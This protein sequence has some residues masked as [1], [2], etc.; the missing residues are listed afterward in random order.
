VARQTI[1]EIAELTDAVEKC[2]RLTY[3]E[4]IF[5]WRGEWGEAD[6]LLD[7]LI[8]QVDRYSIASYRGIAMALKGELLVKTG[9]PEE[10]CRRL[11]AADSMLK[12]TRNTALDTTFAAALAEGLAATG[13]SDEALVTLEAAI[14]LAY[15]RGGTWDLPDLLRMK[16]MLLALRSPGDDGAVNDALS[17]A[18]E[19]ARRQG[20]LA[21]ELRATTALAR[22]RL[23]RGGT[24]HDLRDLSAVYA[25]FTEGLQTP[26]LQAARNL[27]DRDGRNRKRGSRTS[28]GARLVVRR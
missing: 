27:L 5:V 18:I 22:E 9:R 7:M 1:N 24:A 6:R 16:G 23:R 14:E 2:L 12:A 17:A 26:D 20:A 28:P 21:W 10:G 3:G 11:R 15:R 13:S 19:L 8:E 25:K 4:M